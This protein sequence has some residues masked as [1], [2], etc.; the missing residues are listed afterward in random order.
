M[1]QLRRSRIVIG[2]LLVAAVGVACSKAPTAATGPSPTKKVNFLACQVTD[3]GGID[4]RSFNATAWKGVLDAEKELGVQGKYLE[5][6]TQNDYAPNINQ[7]LQQNCGIIVTVG[8]LLG[9]ATK[10]AATANCE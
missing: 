2:V 10:A 4:D 7:F 6:T 1:R 9:D 3:T 5:S 8:F